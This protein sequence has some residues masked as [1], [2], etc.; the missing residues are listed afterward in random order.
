MKEIN[1]IQPVTAVCYGG[2]IMFCKKCAAKIPDDSVFCPECGEK[3]TA[4]D[5]S[6]G[7]TQKVRTQYRQPQSPQVQTPVYDASSAP[8]STG[9][10]FWLPV[11][12]AIPIVGIILILVWAFSKNANVNRKHYA[13][14]VLIW[15]LIGLIL[16]VIVYLTTGGIPGIL[17]ALK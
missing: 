17:N 12:T 11:I 5:P 7:N 9:N 14:A 8:L 2:H 15:L 13:R 1:R 4:D 16:T 10:F 6:G 3:L